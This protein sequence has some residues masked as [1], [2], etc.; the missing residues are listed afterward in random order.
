M[1]CR[2]HHRPSVGKMMKNG[3][4]TRIILY[5]SLYTFNL[6]YISLYTNLLTEAQEVSNFF[7]EFDMEPST[8]AYAL[9]KWF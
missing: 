4:K 6:L 7:Q 1:A 3:G 2:S 9:G 8:R 5:S